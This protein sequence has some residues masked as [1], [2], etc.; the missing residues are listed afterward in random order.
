MM[1]NNMISKIT[2]I[3]ALI[4]C[5]GM[6]TG[7]VGLE[8]EL[9]INDSQ[10]GTD[11]QNVT[12]SQNV[13]DAQN[14]TDNQNVTDTQN[15]IDNQS[16]IDDPNATYFTF[17]TFDIDDKQFT[18]EM[19]KDAKLV[20]INF[21]EPWCGPCVGE[22]SDIETLYEN[23]KGDGFVVLGIFST[24]GMDDDVHSVMS[25]CGTT[26]PIL[27]ATEDM[28]DFMTDYVPTTFF[29]DGNGKV[30]SDEPIIGSKSYEAWEAQIQ[31]YLK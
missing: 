13:A 18:S 27:R 17:D 26:Y 7:C 31:S 22:M 24:L 14:T 8:E 5:V 3:L 28:Y 2:K 1:K 20:M 4:L 29:M 30:L 12:D 6:L 19:V 11:I 25:N 9:T 15:T 21:W 23:Y 16:V 10:S